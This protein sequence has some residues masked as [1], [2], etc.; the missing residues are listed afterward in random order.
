MG[1]RVLDRNGGRRLRPQ[2]DAV[3]G[4]GAGA[5][6]PPLPAH[7]G[8]DRALQGAL[9]DL[10]AHHVGE[11]VRTAG[12]RFDYRSFPEMGHAMHTIDPK[13]YS[14]TLRDWLAAVLPSE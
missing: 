5:A 2:A 11:L 3:R 6:H 7:R 9:S 14:S 12:P 8:G 1:P 13:L 10:Q 4:E